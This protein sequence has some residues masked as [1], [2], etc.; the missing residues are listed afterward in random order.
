TLGNKVPAFKNLNSKTY[1]EVGT[2]I[3]NI[4]KVLRLDLVWR[5]SPTPIYAGKKNQFGAF[6]SFQF[7]F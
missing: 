1:L 2:G 3:D 5:V 6:V 7:Q 4:L